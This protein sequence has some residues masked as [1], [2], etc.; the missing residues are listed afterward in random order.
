MLVPFA[1]HLNFTSRFVQSANKNLQRGVFLRER[2]RPGSYSRARKSKQREAGEKGKK[3]RKDKTALKKLLILA[4]EMTMIYN[5]FLFD[6]ITSV[7]GPHG[8]EQT[9]F[10]CNVEL[11]CNFNLIVFNPNCVI[12]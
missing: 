12:A 10:S 7:N 1:A 9:R 6:K 2:R 3:E 8:K 11:L 4:N 5:Q